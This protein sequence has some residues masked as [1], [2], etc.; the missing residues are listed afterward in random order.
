MLQNRIRTLDNLLAGVVGYR[1]TGNAYNQRNLQA[2]TEIYAHPEKGMVVGDLEDSLNP[3]KREKIYRAVESLPFDDYTKQKVE[4]NLATKDYVAELLVSYL[5]SKEGQKVSSKYG[6]KL[7]DLKPAGADLEKS[8]VAATTKQVYP[9]PV[10]KNTQDRQRFADYVKSIEPSLSDYDVDTLWLRHEIRHLT[11]DSSLLASATSSLENRLHVEVDNIVGLF[12]EY[13]HE[14]KESKDY[15][16]KDKLAAKARFTL[17]HYLGTKGAL[18]KEQQK[19]YDINQ[20]LYDVALGCKKNLSPEDYSI[21]FGG[22]GNI[23]QEYKKAA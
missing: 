14:I 22:A 6:L 3:E 10:I 21:L 7:S 18:E 12:K 23:S 15:G 16:E 8:V 17:I 4:E 1:M 19:A 5:N 9:Y 20:E 11:Q 2:M 13:V